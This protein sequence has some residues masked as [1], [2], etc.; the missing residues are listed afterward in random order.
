MVASGDELGVLHGVPF[1]VKDWIETAG[2]VCA[3]GYEERRNHVPKRDA[4]VVARMRAA[5]AILL[6]KTNV[7]EGGA[8]LPRPANP[9]DLTRTQGSSTSGE[10]AIIAAGG[11]PL[12]I[13][14]DSGGSIRW[15]AHCCGVAGLKPTTGR[16]PSTGHFPRIT[17]LADSRT[18]IGPIA[19]SVDDLALALRI[20]GGP[21]G[22]DASVVP[23][24][25]GDPTEVGI[26]SL[27]VAWYAGMPGASPSRETVDVVRKV[28]S[29]LRD[30]CASVEEAL[31]P[32]IEEALGIT[33]AYWKRV[34]SLSLNEWTPHRPSV[35]TADEI[36][37]SIFE[38]DRFRRTMT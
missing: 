19:R 31:P 24:P 13:A 20:I 10:C 30:V 7:V 5:G 38:W 32:R 28:S 4:T 18:Q 36:E 26:R 12:G 27:R 15:P 2:V 11:S 34:D 16:V 29:V 17:A 1:T 14:S 35:L 37:Q 9:Y 8:V 21:D 23:T 33:Q 25:L 22:Q 3:A 6:G